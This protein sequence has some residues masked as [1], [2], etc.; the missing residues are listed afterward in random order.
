MEPSFLVLSAATPKLMERLIQDLAPVPDDFDRNYFLFAEQVYGEDLLAHP[1]L[2]FLYSEAFD[3]GFSYTGLPRYANA[4]P[5]HA[6]LLKLVHSSFPKKTLL[7]FVQHH[8]PYDDFLLRVAGNACLKQQF[9]CM[10]EYI[11]GFLQRYRMGVRL[12]GYFRSRHRE[13]FERVN[14]MLVTFKATVHEWS[15]LLGHFAIVLS[16]KHED[17]GAVDFF[18]EGN[19]L[20][21]IKDLPLSY[22]EDALKRLRLC[23]GEFGLYSLVRPLVEKGQIDVLEKTAGFWD[24]CFV[25]PSD[26]ELDPVTLEPVGS[27]KPYFERFGNFHGGS[28]FIL[29]HLGLGIVYAEEMDFLSHFYNAVGGS[30]KS[31]LEYL[32]AESLGCEYLRGVVQY[33]VIVGFLSRYRDSVGLTRIYL[34]GFASAFI[35]VMEQVF[36]H[37]FGDAELLNTTTVFRLGISALWEFF[38]GTSEFMDHTIGRDFPPFLEFSTMKQEV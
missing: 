6:D 13:A 32:G 36:R 17:V 12:Y 23:K 2:K 9:G 35:F 5:G 1:T 22:W 3:V 38:V 31:F 21:L 28:N 7:D 30:N 25:N 27:V 26:V 18:P 29:E 14:D 20:M 4:W 19:Y 15:Y 37:G 11:S 8:Y 16:D 24:T 34:N 10:Y 33:G